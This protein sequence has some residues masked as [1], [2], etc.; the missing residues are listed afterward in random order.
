MQSK[1]I[2][3]K[4]I[5]TC[6]EK[7]GVESSLQSQE[8]KDKIKATCMEKYGVENPMQNAE[9]SE[10]SSKNAYKAYDYTFPSGRIERIQGY[11]RFM[12]DDLLLKENIQEDDIVVKRTE[13]PSCF[14]HDELLKK[15]RYYVDCFIKSQKRCIEAKSTWTAK[16]N[17]DKI[18]LKQQAL[19]DLGFKCEI[20]IYDPI[21]EIIEK[22]Y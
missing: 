5:A 3:D 18:Y 19:K 17:E 13:V 8:I 14:Y 11:E 20:W 22:I 12:L 16:K 6:M 9:I 21:G 15:H 7:Y 1:E 10:N 4:T 2:R